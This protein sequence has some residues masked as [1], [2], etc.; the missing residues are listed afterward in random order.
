MQR[1]SFSVL[2]TSFSGKSY[3]LM[4]QASINYLKIH[5][6]TCTHACAFTYVRPGTGAF[7]MCCDKVTAW[8][9]SNIRNSLSVWTAKSCPFTQSLCSQ[10]LSC[11]RGCAPDCAESVNILFSWFT[12]TSVQ[13]WQWYSQQDQLL[14]KCPQNMQ[15][16]CHKTLHHRQPITKWLSR[17]FA[18]HKPGE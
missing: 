2:W 15:L 11:M 4:K 18:W 5:V 12:L 1:L 3:I 8:I 13:L 14:Q 17:G 7:T 10:P 9:K 16:V 6:C